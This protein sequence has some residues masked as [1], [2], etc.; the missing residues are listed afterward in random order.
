V[1]RAQQKSVENDVNSDRNAKI[2]FFFI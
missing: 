2:L 1:G